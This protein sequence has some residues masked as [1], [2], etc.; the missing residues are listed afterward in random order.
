MRTTVQRSPG[1]EGLGLLDRTLV[2]SAVLLVMLLIGVQ[3]TRAA[4]G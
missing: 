2:G 3:L 1:E 4:T